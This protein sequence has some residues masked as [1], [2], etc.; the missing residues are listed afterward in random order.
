MA[1]KIIDREARRKEILMAAM[2]VS[3]AKGIKNVKIDE[4]AEAAGVGKGTI[5]EYFS[6]KEEIFGASIV[7]FLQHM[8]KIMAQKMFRAVTPQD[9]IR[10][11][12]HSWEEACKNEDN[13]LVALMIDVWAEG[14]RR[15]NKELLKIFNMKKVYER[16]R[17]MVSAILK[18][19]INQGV[20]RQIDVITVAG[21][22]LATFDGI[23]I[24]WLLDS[25]NTDL[26]KTADVLYE[27]LMLGIIAK[28]DN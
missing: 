16:Y 3:A 9:K 12:L 17:E 20:F 10:A 2:K 14:I 27:T 21:L 13:D 26:K 4:I 28:T 23:M 11:M 1:P 7:E 5:Y 15:D 18:E 8:E 22:L 6:S 24:Q 25:E 19:G